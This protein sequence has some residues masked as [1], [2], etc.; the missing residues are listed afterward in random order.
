MG[1]L[2]DKVV[3]VTGASRGIGR[4]IAQRFFAEGA[5]VTIGSRSDT[6]VAGVEWIETDVASAASAQALIAHAV[7]THGQLDVLVNN[8]G[9]QVEK[10]VTE[11]TDDDYELVMG[12]NVRGTFNCC[13]AAIPHLADAGG[14][15]IINIGSV[16][17]QLADQ[18]MALYNASKGAVH[19][20]TR[21][22]AIDHGREGVRCNAIAPGWIETELAEAAFAQMDDPAEARAD[23]ISRHPVPRL[24]DP[25]DVAGLAVWLASD[26]AG[27]VTG[28]VFTIDGGLT[29]GSP[30][31]DPYPA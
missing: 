27:F 25:A 3:V 23:A 8:A 4:V 15:S 26:G 30:I 16:A 19:A 13:R 29:A 21:S 24:G 9:V 5:L 10:P 18:R 14:G 11:T 6:S 17:G 12:V 28:S 31:R 22:I 2:T 7:D 1:Q 20:L